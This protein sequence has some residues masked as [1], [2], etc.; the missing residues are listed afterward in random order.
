V[1]RV[2][3]LKWYLLGCLIG[4]LVLVGVSVF[5]PGK[6]T[7]AVEWVGNSNFACKARA[8]MEKE[9]AEEPT[10]I[11]MVVDTVGLSKIDYTPVV[12]L[13]EKT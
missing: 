11:E 7:N 8:L 9:V 13:K 10:Q 5:I 1:G 2:S 12:I 3:Q 4:V 6:L